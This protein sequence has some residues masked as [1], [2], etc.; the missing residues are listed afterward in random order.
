GRRRRRTR[1]GRAR[2][3]NGRSE[4][5]GPSQGAKIAISSH[6]SAFS[7]WFF[8]GP[9]LAL[10]LYSLRGERRRAAYVEARL[11]TQ[12]EQFPPATVIVPVKGPDEGLRQNLAALAA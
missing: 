8:A 5:Q 7:Y 12:P 4:G 6:L 1:R 3:G 2:E 11:N 9:A 10:A